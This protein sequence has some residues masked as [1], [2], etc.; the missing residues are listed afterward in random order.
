MSVRTGRA[1]A[2]QDHHSLEVEPY[3]TERC[4]RT[5]PPRRSR[6]K[7]G[8]AFCGRP[9]SARADLPPL[10]RPGAGEPHDR[11]PDISRR[12]GAR[13]LNDPSLV[14]AFNNKQLPIADGHHRYRPRSPRRGRGNAGERADAGR[15]G[16]DDDPA[17]ECFRPTGSSRAAGTRERDE[18]RR[19]VTEVARDGSRRVDGP[20]GNLDVQ[21][22]DTLGHDGIWH[23]RAP[24]RPNGASATVKLP[25]PT[26]C[27]RRRSRTSS[28]TRDAAR[29]CP[30]RRPTS[31]RS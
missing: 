16:L 4:S 25:S 27:G 10:R 18:R 26:C 5:A 11:A 8:F 14:R 23:R 30:R 28:P 3:G 13:R 9:A 21:L 1:P 22:V 7:A 6:R 17:L 12:R 20:G 24:R 29:C 15:A 31:S 2:L 19:Q